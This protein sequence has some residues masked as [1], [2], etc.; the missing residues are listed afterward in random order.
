MGEATKTERLAK[1]KSNLVSRL[2]KFKACIEEA[3]DRKALEKCKRKAAN[4]FAKT[5]EKKRADTK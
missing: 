1:Q 3:E 4:F 5:P 2:E